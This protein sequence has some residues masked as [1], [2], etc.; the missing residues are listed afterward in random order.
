MEKGVLSKVI[1]MEN[2]VFKCGY[3]CMYISMAE[4]CHG[5]LRVS[6]EIET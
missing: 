4:K 2:W 6:D 3:D 1:M 5:K